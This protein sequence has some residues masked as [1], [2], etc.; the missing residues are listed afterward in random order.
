MRIILIKVGLILLT[1]AAFAAVLFFAPRPA[2]PPTSTE[3]S[4]DDQLWSAV[5]VYCG[6]KD[7]GG[8]PDISQIG[9]DNRYPMKVWEKWRVIPEDDANPTDRFEPA[10]CRRTFEIDVRAVGAPKT[11]PEEW[12]GTIVVTISPE[13]IIAEILGED[14]FEEEPTKNQLFDRAATVQ[15]LRKRGLGWILDLDLRN[16]VVERRFWIDL[17]TAEIQDR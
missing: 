17:Q 9:P 12:V 4:W 11:W 8:A 15:L 6:F 3:P 10:I 1:T 13:G 16:R 2:P 7:D 14:W 5:A